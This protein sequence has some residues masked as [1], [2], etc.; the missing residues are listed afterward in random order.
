MPRTCPDCNIALDARDFQGITIDA[1]PKCAGIFF[2]DGEVAAIKA[3]GLDAMDEL[4]KAVVPQVTT[5]AAQ[6]KFRRCSNC[7]SAM[8][9][10]RYMYHSDVVL[11]Q[12]ERCG[13]IWVQDGELGRMREVLAASGVSKEPRS[14]TV[15]W[16]DSGHTE[17]SPAEG[18]MQKVQG[19]LRT[20]GRRLQGQSA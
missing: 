7:G 15:V 2:D 4:E 20:I 13:G 11:D 18:R 19:F 17:E 1:C 14:V 16:A 5:E 6:G 3:K 8:D 10:F 12:C 9:K